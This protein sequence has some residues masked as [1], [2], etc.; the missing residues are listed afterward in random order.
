MPLVRTNESQYAFPAASAPS[1]GA[2]P[3]SGRKIG[4]LTSGAPNGSAIVA[5]ATGTVIETAAIATTKVRR[6]RNGLRHEN[7]ERVREVAFQRHL[8]A[9]GPFAALEPDRRAHSLIRVSN[10]YPARREHVRELARDLDAVL[11]AHSLHQHGDLVRAQLV[12]RLQVGVPAEMV[13]R[14]AS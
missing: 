10:C 2:V 7:V 11:L 3:S 8:E 6:L 1:T 13:V 14:E 4:S 9:F 12:V 5:T